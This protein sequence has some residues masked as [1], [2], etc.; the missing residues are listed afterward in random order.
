MRRVLSLSNELALLQHATEGARLLVDQFATNPP[1]AWAM[2]RTLPTAVVA[3]LTLLEARVRQLDRA[4]RGV[5]DPA[6][7]W[8]SWSESGGPS[9]GEETALILREGSAT[10]ELARLEADL[11]RAR[12]RRE[13]RQKNCRKR[14][15]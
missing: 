10:Q 6:G 11:H 4:V 3:V 8:T 13:F 5:V 7:I 14:S 15:R 12:R 2:M 9:P 1:D